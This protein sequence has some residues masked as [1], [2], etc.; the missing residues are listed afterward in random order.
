MSL[1]LPPPPHPPPPFPPLFQFHQPQRFSD[2]FWRLLAALERQLGCLVG[3]NTYLTPPG[4]QGA[5]EKGVPGF[6]GCP[7]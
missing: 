5:H 6:E 2:D 1:P 7:G 3:A 4:T